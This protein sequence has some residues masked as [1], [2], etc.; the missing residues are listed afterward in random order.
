AVLGYVDPSAIPL[1]VG[2]V[3]WTLVY[4][5]IYALQ[6]VK[7]DKLVGIKSTAIRFGANLK[8]YLTFFAVLSV[9][10]FTTSGIM[11][12][13]S[14]FYYI[15]SVGGTSIHYVW[16]IFTLKPENIADCAK[17]FKSNRNF[18]LILALGI[19]LDKLYKNF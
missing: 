6:D 1:Y 16:Q 15:V 18:G 4:D 19:I 12:D 13:S 7:D 3:C 10:A 5:T 11:N 2:G 17:K 9:A 14:L 8:K